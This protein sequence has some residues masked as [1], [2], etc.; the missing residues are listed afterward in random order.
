MIE[1]TFALMVGIV[2]G[3]SYNW[4]VSLV[5]LG[6]TPFM[7][8]GGFINAKLQ[9]GG[10]SDPNETSYKDANLLAGDAIANYRTLQSFAHNEVILN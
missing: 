7:V 4:K 1:S 2:I 9:S 6:C 10:M 5:A 3:F 8:L